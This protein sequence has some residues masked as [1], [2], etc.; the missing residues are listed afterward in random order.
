MDGFMGHVLGA[1]NKHG[2]RAIRI[3]P[4]EAGVLLGFADRLA[5][6]VVRYQS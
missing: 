4:K 5:T 3:F 1:L 6:D 2:S